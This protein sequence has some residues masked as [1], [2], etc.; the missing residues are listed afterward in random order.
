M[1]VVWH[2][3]LLHFWRSAM[4]YPA[5]ILCCLVTMLALAGCGETTRPS[6]PAPTA[7]VEVLSTTTPSPEP[8]PAAAPTVAPAPL[9]SPTA[10]S[11][12]K[13]KLER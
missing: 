4:N 10:A 7:A 1:R 11:S 2:F 13:R 3:R 9:P 8:S 5:F 6:S 12:L